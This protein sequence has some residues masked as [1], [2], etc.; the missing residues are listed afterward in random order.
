MTKVS[1][2]VL[3]LCA[4]LSPVCAQDSTSDFP[5]L[6]GPYLG[7]EP[8]G[9]TPELFAPGIVSTEQNTDFSASFSPDGTEFYFSRREPEGTNQ[10]LFS[11]LKNKAWTKPRVVSFVKH[12]DASEASVSPDGKYILFG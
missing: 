12:H 5:V 7:Q 1:T 9:K 6:E 8:P 4:T 11:R 2:A 3:V 10:L